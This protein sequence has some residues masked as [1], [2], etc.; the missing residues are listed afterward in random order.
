MNRNL[1][2]NASA[3]GVAAGPEHTQQAVEQF[4]NAQ[5]CGSEESALPA[6]GRRYFLEIEAHRY[7]HEPHILQLLDAIDWR[8]KRVLEIG[9]GVGTDARQL[10]ARGAIYSGINVDAGSTELA[11]RALAAF[12]LPGRIEQAG[13]AQLPFADASFDLIYSFGVL[14]HIPDVAAAVREMHRVLAPGGRCVLMV[15]NRDSINYQ[16]EIRRLRRLA[17]RLLLL[18]GATRAFVRL[19]L[20]EDKI[21][22]HTALARRART[23]SAQEW[24]NHNTNG[25]GNPHTV[26]YSDTELREVLADLFCIES[27]TI[28]FFDAR[29]WGVLGRALPAAAV[30]GLGRRW[31]WH[32]MVVARRVSGSQ[33]SGPQ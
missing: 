1:A 19:G 23:M 25:V 28:G 18:P 29:H 32:R 14:H 11:R 26:V 8:G 4:W 15:Y 30:R 7:R 12:H 13:A 33:R 10:I 9:A 2:A 5:P 21:A 22:A 6:G 20:P 16:I 17:S 24:L 3:P 27:S 31:G